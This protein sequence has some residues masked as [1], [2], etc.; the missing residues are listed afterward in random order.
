MLVCP[1][2]NLQLE[3][4]DHFTQ[5]PYFCSQPEEFVGAENVFGLHSAFQPFS[6]QFGEHRMEER[7]EEREEKKKMMMILKLLQLQ[8]RESLRSQRPFQ[9]R[10]LQR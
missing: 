8:R 7:V 3:E 10:R 1:K 9:R 2:K 6:N 5:N 4:M